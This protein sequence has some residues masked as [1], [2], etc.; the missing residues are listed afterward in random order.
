[1]IIIIHNN[2]NIAGK[3][4]NIIFYENNFELGF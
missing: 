2:T 1:M 4:F 3:D